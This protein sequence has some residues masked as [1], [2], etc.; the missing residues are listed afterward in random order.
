[1]IVD[2]QL[3]SVVSGARF[4]PSFEDVEKFLEED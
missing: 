3:N 2:A 4:D 1:M